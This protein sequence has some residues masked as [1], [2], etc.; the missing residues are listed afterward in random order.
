M[1]NNYLNRSVILKILGLLTFAIGLDWLL[2]R[3]EVIPA[4]LIGLLSLLAPLLMGAAIAF[5]LNLPLRLIEHLIFRKPFAQSEP[6]F[7]DRYEKTEPINI[8][9]AL[10]NEKQKVQVK[11]KNQIIYNINKYKKA[12]NR[13][14]LIRIRDASI[15]PVSLFLSLVLVLGLIVAVMVIVVPELINSIQSLIKN[16]P[17]FLAS[18]QK[19]IQDR[20]SAY[21]E[22]E[23]FS[24]SFK[25]N[26]PQIEAA[27]VKWLEFGAGSMLETT[28]KFATAVFGGAFNILL[29]IV[30]AIYILFHKETLNQQARL[31]LKAFVPDN[32]AIAI[33]RISTLTNQSFNNFIVGQFIEAIILGLLFLV[34]MSIFGFPYVV[35]ISVV[36]AFTALVPMIGSFVGGAISALLVLMASPK[37]F[38]W[39]LILF[40]VLQQIENN[41]IYPRVVGKSIG[42]PG[43]WVLIAVIIG[44]KLFG[45]IGII[46]FIPVFSIIYVLIREYTYKRI[47]NK[48]KKE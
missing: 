43:M 15:R 21:P 31:L 20:L 2:Q 45:V 46:L 36:I 18:T 39:F 48:V 1:N 26:V 34:V 41:L 24:S 4:F 17:V 6:I 14:L 8:D 42:L 37:Q 40:I 27:V 10:E 35:L 25:F 28:F 29:S 23:R 38:I 5:L 19:W 47:K 22:L 13:S 11:P 7:L 30:V 3:Y 16:F 32:K 33:M 44:G 9:K 12:L